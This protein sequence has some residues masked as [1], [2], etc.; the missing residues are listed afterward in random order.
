MLKTQTFEKKGNLSSEKKCLTS[1]SRIIEHTNTQ[2]TLYEGPKGILTFT[3]ELIRAFFRT[4]EVVENTIFEEKG[5]PS[6][7]K[8][9]LTSF[10]SYYRLWQ[11]SR[12]NL[13]GSASYSYQYCMNYSRIFLGPKKL[14]KTQTF[15]K[16]Q[17]FHWK[18]IW[19]LFS[20]IIERQK[21][22]ETKYK[23]PQA[24]FTIAL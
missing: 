8:K 14:L 22:Q 4:W 7:E 13:K 10:N 20:R 21:A 18:K 12:N 15:E 23:G 9:Y 16:R 19:R 1:F 2:E 6:S 24:I 3:V 11:T 17:A 5:N